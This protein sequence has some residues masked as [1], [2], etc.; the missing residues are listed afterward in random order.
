[1][2]IAPAYSERRAAGTL[3]FPIKRTP[4]WERLLTALE[5]KKPAGWTRFGHR[6]LNATIDGQ[7]T[8]EQRVKTGRKAVAKAPDHFFTSAV[9]WGQGEHR[10]T[11]AFAVGAPDGPKQFQENLQYA[12][13]S[14]F[15]QGGSADLLL[16]YWFFPPTGEAYDFIGTMRRTQLG[17]IG[18]DSRLVR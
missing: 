2:Q 10:H 7:R 9:T 6:L 16:L 14:A 11:I 3:S 4:L 17:G 8:F 15:E 5:D 1:M 13:N 18:P 12:S